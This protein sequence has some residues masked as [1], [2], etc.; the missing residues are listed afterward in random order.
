MEPS[1]PESAD[2]AVIEGVGHYILPRLHPVVL[3]SRLLWSSIGLGDEL[4]T[5]ADALAESIRLV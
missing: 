5:V 1:A 3:E 4:A 2:G